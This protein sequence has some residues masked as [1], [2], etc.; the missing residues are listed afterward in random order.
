MNL[1]KAIILLIFTSLSLTSFKFSKPTLPP[2]KLGDICPKYGTP[3]IVCRAV[4]ELESRGNHAAKRFEPGQMA[5]AARLTDNPR[6]REEYATSWGSM[7]VMGWWAPAMGISINELVQ[8]AEDPEEGVHLGS[9]ILG[10]CWEQAT[11][12]VKQLPLRQRSIASEEK[13]LLEITARTGRCYNGS[14]EYGQKLSKLVA[15]LIS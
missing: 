13:R 6:L 7:Q 15:T 9:A 10:R 14:I 8:S 5:R 12:Q 3:E 11:K 1:T 4:V 2:E